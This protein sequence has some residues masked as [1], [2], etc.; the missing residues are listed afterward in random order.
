MDSSKW[1]RKCVLLHNGNVYGSIPTGHLVELKEN[2][3]SV[4]QVLYSRQYKSNNWKICVDLKIVNFLLGQQSGY[5]KYPCILCY[6]DRRAKQKHCYT[7]KQK[8]WCSVS[9]PERESLNCGDRNVIIDSLVDRN[10]ILLPP[11]HIKLGMM[12]Q[13]VKALNH[14]QTHLCS[15]LWST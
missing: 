4:K 14:D 12:K 13:F 15:F 3:C 7:A 6:W 5:T 2:H 11:L 9:W 1:G 10:N 8:R